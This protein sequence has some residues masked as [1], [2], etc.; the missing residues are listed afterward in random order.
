M[1]RKV[2]RSLFAFCSHFSFVRSFSFELVQLLH[3]FTFFLTLPQS[4]AAAHNIY[5]LITLGFLNDAFK[6][7][8]YTASTDKMIG[9]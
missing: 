3:F 9:Q 8:P 7:M 6:T 4:N 2:A 5:F 1:S